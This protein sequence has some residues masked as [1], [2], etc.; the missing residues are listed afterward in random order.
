MGY[1]Y[2]YTANIDSRNN[3][4]YPWVVEDRGEKGE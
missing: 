4:T 2:A 1:R 3:M